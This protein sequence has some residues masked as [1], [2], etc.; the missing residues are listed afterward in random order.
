M[1]DNIVTSNHSNFLQAQYLKKCYEE[2]LEKAKHVESRTELFQRTLSFL[3]N[4][5]I[6][7]KAAK[8]KELHKVA[9]N[10]LGA[11][12]EEA[13]LK[14]TDEPSCGESNSALFDSMLD[15]YDVK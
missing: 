12:V 15:Q 9:Q 10:L 6:L 4:P 11:E 7:A 3:E 13:S 2:E 14:L 5:K 8:S 1:P